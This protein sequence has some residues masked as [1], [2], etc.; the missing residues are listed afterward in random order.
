MELAWEWHKGQHKEGANHTL[1]HLAVTWSVYGLGNAMLDH[2]L[3]WAWCDWSLM[4]VLF[5][6]QV[7]SPGFFPPHC[8]SWQCCASTYSFSA[9]FSFQVQI[10]G[11]NLIS[12][13]NHCDLVYSV[14][15][16]CPTPLFPSTAFTISNFFPS[17]SLSLSLRLWT[18]H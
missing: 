4:P 14:S 15:L 6:H 8:W 18:V 3:Q 2:A 10:I 16:A 7:F 13:L 5:G 17:L 9:F 11:D 1:L 12:S